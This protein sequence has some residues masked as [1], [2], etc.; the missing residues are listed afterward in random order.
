MGNISTFPHLANETLKYKFELKILP[1]KYVTPKSLSR[2]A[3]GQVS[4]GVKKNKHHNNMCSQT[5]PRWPRPERY[6]HRYLAWS[7][8][9]GLEGPSRFNLKPMSPK[10][11]LI[12]YFQPNVDVES[13]YK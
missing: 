3:I 1:T 11:M 7:M 2:L 9:E 6:R 12:W 4:Y 10:M 13:S 8:G 5:P